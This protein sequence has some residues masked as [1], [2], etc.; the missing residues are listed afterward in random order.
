[1]CRR[2]LQASPPNVK[3]PSV[4]LSNAQTHIRTAYA[5]SGK[6]TGEI[7]IHVIVQRTCKSAA[8]FRVRMNDS[9]SELCGLS[10]GQ[11]SAQNVTCTEFNNPAVLLQITRTWFHRVNE[12]DVNA[13]RR[14]R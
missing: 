3:L 9:H 10:E 6:L 12:T 4:D 14:Y 1:M 13:P 7:I 8:I 2:P 5:I 11:L